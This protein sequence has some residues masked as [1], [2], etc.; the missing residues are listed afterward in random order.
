M[1][2]L[3]ILTVPHPVLAQKAR[4]VRLDEFGPELARRVSD[5]AETMYAAPGVGLAAPQVGDSRR[6]LVADP[7][8]EGK[9]GKPRRGE[10]FL[11]LINPVILDQSKEKICWEEGCLSVPELWEEIERPRS[12]TVRW[13]DLDG[14][15]HERLFEEFDAVVVQ[16]ELEHLD[17]VVI[18]DH[19]SRFKRARY[20]RTVRKQALK[21]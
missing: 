5:M 11:A 8:A 2:I 16:H 9:D 7:G 13:Q 19:V 17:G 4:A 6:F 18:L 1:A 15:F 10:S 21:V 3:Q 20:L 14:V 12:V